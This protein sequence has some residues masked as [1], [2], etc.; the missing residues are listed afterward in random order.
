MGGDEWGFEGG[1]ETFIF[2]AIITFFFNQI[3][4]KRKTVNPY[5]LLKGSA[6][7]FKSKKSC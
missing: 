4:L 7:K 5:F 2:I 1:R 6:A 3:S